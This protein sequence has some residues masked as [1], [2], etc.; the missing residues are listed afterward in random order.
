MSGVNLEKILANSGPCLSSELAGILVERYGLTPV[1]ARKRISRATSSIN[2]LSYIIF[3]NR[4][5]FIYLISDYASPKY[6]K[7]LYSSL[8]KENSS[9]YMAINSIR[10][11]G[12]IVKIDEFG[13]ICVSPNKQKNQIPN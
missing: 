7:A 5:R 11:R 4:A 8:K 12:G 9:Y 1:A 3:P 13:I 2:K 10:S 6:W